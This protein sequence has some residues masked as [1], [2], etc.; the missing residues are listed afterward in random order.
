[1]DVS[2]LIGYFQESLTEF[3]DFVYGLMNLIRE[4]QFIGSV[5]ELETIYFGWDYYLIFLHFTLQLE[6]Y[7]G[8]HFP[9]Y[10]I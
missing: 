6:D 4:L 7:I 5:F 10:L 2:C 3:I 8:F 1:M 9:F